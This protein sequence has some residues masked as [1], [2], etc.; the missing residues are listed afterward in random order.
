MRTDLAVSRMNDNFPK[1]SNYTVFTN[2]VYFLVYPCIIF[3]LHLAV[4]TPLT[5]C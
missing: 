1:M 4:L 3:A 2:M 5:W